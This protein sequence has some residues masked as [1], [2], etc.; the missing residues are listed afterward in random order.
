MI[1]SD[2][3]KYARTLLNVGYNLIFDSCVLAEFQKGFLRNIELIP[4]ELQYNR[5]LPFRDL[6]VFKNRARLLSYVRHIG[7]VWSFE[8][9][10]MFFTLCCFLFLSPR[11]GV[12]LCL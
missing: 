2:L 10:F 7:P 3:R 5:P 12:K 6:I 4:L 9:D 1:D 11:C 8:P